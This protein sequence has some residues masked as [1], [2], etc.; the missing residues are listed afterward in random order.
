MMSLSKYAKSIGVSYKTAW[1]HHKK[2]LIKCRKSVTGRILVEDGN[3]LHDKC[4]VIYVRSESGEKNERMIAQIRDSCL[5]FQISIKNEVSEVS[6]V[7][8]Y[9]TKFDHVLKSVK[10]WN[11]LLIYDNYLS[12]I[13]VRRILTILLDAMGKRVAFFK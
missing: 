2:G 3:I 9:P 5:K 11:Y 8:V 10:Q 1:T 12:D 7:N 4:G 6:P 13:Y